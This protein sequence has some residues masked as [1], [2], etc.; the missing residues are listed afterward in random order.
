MDAAQVNEAF[1]LMLQAA[2]DRNWA[3][4]A[5]LIVVAVVWAIRYLGE[6]VLPW[7]G[8]DKGGAVVSLVTAWAGAVVSALAAGQPVDMEL[9]VSSLGVAATASGGWTLAKKLVA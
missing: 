3:M 2:R 7:L 4:L 8:T 5:A 1:G 6:P 9:F